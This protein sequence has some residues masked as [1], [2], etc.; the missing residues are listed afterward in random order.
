MMSNADEILNKA[1]TKLKEEYGEDFKFEI[2]DEFVFTLNNGV[3]IISQE[4]TK[5]GIKIMLDTAI[6]LDMDFDLEEGGEE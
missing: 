1:I 2:G 6:P 4:E 5:L 3:L